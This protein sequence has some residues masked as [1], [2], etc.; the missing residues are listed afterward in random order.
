MVMA[1]QLIFALDSR[2]ELD[3][4]TVVLPQIKNACVW[5]CIFTSSFDLSTKQEWC[6]KVYATIWPALEIKA[7]KYL[8]MSLIID[9]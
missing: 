6:P 8:S 4:K 5:Y 7:L 1:N 9:F 2:L 3:P